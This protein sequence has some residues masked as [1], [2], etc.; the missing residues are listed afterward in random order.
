M[1]DTSNATLGTGNNPV[2]LFREVSDGHIVQYQTITCQKE[3]SAFSLEEHRLED[4]SQGKAGTPAD[5]NAQLFTMSSMELSKRMKLDL[6]C[7]S[8]IEIRV[9]MSTLLN[10]DVTISPSN[11]WSLPINL[12]SYYSPFLKAACSKLRQFY[13]DFVVQHFADPNKLHGT[14]GDWDTLLQSH[15]DLRV[16]LLQNFRQDPLMQTHMRDVK[17]YIESNDPYSNGRLKLDGG[18]AQLADREKRD[19]AWDSALAARPK[20][21][22]SDSDLGTKDAPGPEA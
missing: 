18:V 8:G 13:V 10:E 16:L 1:E 6:I 22:E 4:Y 7:G 19:E 15:S 5:T 9:G 12:I 21:Y 3:Y 20:K 14:I 2:I 11:T 17:D